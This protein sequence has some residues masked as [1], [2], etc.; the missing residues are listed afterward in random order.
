MHLIQRATRLIKTWTQNEE[1][2]PKVLE[3]F[4]KANGPLLDQYET[5]PTIALEKE[6]IEKL[7]NF[8]CNY[9]YVAKLN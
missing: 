6:I 4:S 8:C 7:D 1:Y 9:F 5:S 2:V 3:A